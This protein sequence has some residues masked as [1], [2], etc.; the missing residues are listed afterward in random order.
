MLDWDKLRPDSDGWASFEELC[1][2]LAAREKM[3]KGSRFVRLDQ[4]DGGV[5]CFWRMPDG[6]EVGWQAKFFKKGMKSGQ[7]SQIGESIKRAHKTHP[8]MT[9]YVVCVPA[10]RRQQR[11]PPPEFRDEW[12]EWAEEWMKETGMD[13]E[14]W[15][16][17]EIEERLGREEHAGRRRYFFDKEYLSASWF[18][19][20][21]AVAISRVV[22]R[23]V[24]ET[25]VDLPISFAFDCLCMT[26]K[27]HETLQAMANRIRTNYS[28]AATQ[29]ARSCA[30]D[31][32]DGLATEVD[33]VASAVADHASPVDPIDFNA[34][35]KSADRA[36]DHT[37]KI[38]DALDKR[39]GE[40]AAG[41]AGG[42]DHIGKPFGHELHY[43]GKLRLLL[44]ELHATV[45]DDMHE[46]A[47]KKALVVRG[48]AGAGK[49]HLFCDVAG[50]R[51]KDGLP[52]ILLYGSDFE[53]GDPLAGIKTLLD[54]DTTASEFLSALDAAGEASG[55]RALI[56]IDALNEGAG[57]KVWPN[58]LVKL[59]DTVGS[60]PWVAVALSVRTA[61]EG[62][63]IPEGVVPGKAASITHAGFGDLTDKAMQVFFDGNN[64]KRPSMPLL[65]PEFSNPLFLK[66][67][68]EGLKNM[69]ATQVP[70]D[71]FALMPVYN[72][73]TDSVNKKISGPN[74]L[75]LPPEA[76]IVGKAIGAMSELMIG[77][78]S[79]R[80]DYMDAYERLKQVHPE[81]SE[82][83][84]LLTLLIREGLL[85]E[86]YPNTATAPRRVVG[87][88]YERLAENLV[89]RSLLD[90]IAADDLPR[91]L[92]GSG[93]PGRS[94]KSMWARRGMAEALSIQIP[95]K[96]GMELIEVAPSDARSDLYAPFLASLAWRRPSSVGDYAAGLVA[97]Y[98]RR[99]GDPHA[100]FKPLL[101]VSVAP[102]HRLNAKYLDSLLQRLTMAGR[103]ATWSIFL[104][105][106]HG[107]DDSTVRR[108]IAWGRDADKSAVRP[109]VVELAGITLGWFLTCHNRVV[110]DGATKALVSL[111]SAHT[112]TLIRILDR[113]SEC[114]DPYVM[115][116]L[117]CAAYGCAVHAR[118]DDDLAR[119][120]MYV[121]KAVFEGGSPPADVMLRD[122]A[123]LIVDTALKSGVNLDIDVGKCTPPY[124]SEWAG[125]LPTQEQV[126]ELKDK[127]MGTDP[128]FDGAA[129]LFASLGKFGD[130]RTYVIGRGMGLPEWSDTRL[131]PGRLPRVVAL[132]KLGRSMTTEQRPHWGRLLRLLCSK[133][134]RGDV[135]A[136]A[137]GEQMAPQGFDPEQ[138]TK[139]QAK[140]LKA[141][142]SPD[143]LARL[144]DALSWF[145]LPEQVAE[146]LG[147]HSN[148]D[149]FARW[150]AARVFEM[151]W[152]SSLFSQHDGMI[153]RHRLPLRSTG[154]ERVGKKYQWIAYRELL[155]RLCDNCELNGD[156]RRQEF[157]AY[158]SSRQMRH[159]RDIDPSLLLSGPHPCQD[160]R[161]ALDAP[162][163]AYRHDWRDH[164]DDMEWI[165][166]RAGLP[167][168]E[169]MASI[170]GSDGVEWLV[171]GTFFRLDHR[172]PEDQ[173]AYTTPYRAFEFHMESFLVERAN[174]TAQAK[175][176]SL[177]GSWEPVLQDQGL[178]RRAFIGE[179]YG[180]AGFSALDCAPDSPC[181]A[182]PA[183]PGRALVVPCPIVNVVR[184]NFGEYDYS[185]AEPF[186]LRL[187]DKV[188]ADGMGLRHDGGGSFRDKSGK[189]IAYDPS[190]TECGPSALLLRRD[191]A[192]EFLHKSGYGIVWR[193]YAHKSVLGDLAMSADEWLGE[194]FM[195]AGCSLADGAI[196]AE[197]TFDDGGGSRGQ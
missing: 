141:L 196:K 161:G 11:E 164:L 175:R 95:E 30:E 127:H 34:I 137:D 188:L 152:K 165:K 106:D 153:R 21:L 50:R 60:Y 48:D 32:L 108:L 156:S 29:D 20:K 55:S 181:E 114:D 94:L 79:L 179:E 65:A 112:D 49:T 88:A 91:L 154:L 6:T 128:Q 73:Y 173:E 140:Q 37:E 150:I 47:N 169:K 130:F 144:D 133:A 182:A 180:P 174:A 5:E 192:E 186:D 78:G 109:E 172:V 139:V 116:R 68:C 143:Q 82:S 185:V 178:P 74:L 26:P 104:D 71:E 107:E 145:N 168:V 110:R 135:A 58:Y 148:P 76:N 162:F 92:T 103:D 31:D 18:E 86:D 41:A 166:E 183:V 72:M 9:R 75:D 118:S 16:S 59:L 191:A 22:L 19:E 38:I 131:L 28:R 170:A 70:G 84:S 1:C 7:K 81:P 115:E 64:I 56:L 35:G 159:G 123:R 119:L 120:A 14:F 132:E 100:A 40:L 57:D 61:Y 52:T 129:T 184:S 124:D 177:P 17:A 36:R 151:G 25:H 80:V 33:A 69:G 42:S 98:L 194:L 101:A 102:G 147:P 160:P 142:L 122:Y 44:A 13:V 90:G 27:F 163:I 45:E 197:A 12:N 195:Y 66:M 171:L 136:P 87:F 117:Y 53:G 24:P 149:G 125:E 190:T 158:Y 63:V 10:N 43:L 89:V 46:A 3:P 157:E 113:F 97:E 2:Q 187:P 54:L 105:S 85:R 23:Y 77:R 126:D 138:A 155:A 15:G 111:L 93:E 99:G 4:Q 51:G 62:Q 39:R 8:R 134:G 193:A 96:F 121:Y 167:S 189:L 176:W 146:P 83:K 67:L